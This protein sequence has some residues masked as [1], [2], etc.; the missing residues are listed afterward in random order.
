MKPFWQVAGP[1]ASA[2]WSV[3]ALLPAQRHSLG[4]RVG[5]RTYRATCALPHGIRTTSTTPCTITSQSNRSGTEQFFAQYCTNAVDH[6][7]PARVS[8]SSSSTGLQLPQRYHI[9]TSR[10]LMVC[11]CRPPIQLP[12]IGNALRRGRS[13]PRR[14]ELR[15]WASGRSNGIFYQPSILA[16]IG[17]AGRSGR[18]TA[19][20]RREANAPVR[21]RLR[22]RR[23]SPT[24]C[25]Q[26]GSIGVSHRRTRTLQR[27]DLGT[28]R[29]LTGMGLH[30]PGIRLRQVQLEEMDLLAYP[31]DH[32]AKVHLRM[33]RRMRQKHERL[34]VAWRQSPA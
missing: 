12:G 29:R 2:T 8:H 11:A 28:L 1:R 10:S 20:D 30:Q 16:L 4:R 3:R 27:A 15:V 6:T 34:T 19:S 7:R 17:L 21:A 5:Q 24:R 33:G 23:P 13:A 31:A 14:L 9:G 18:R 32:L 22:C 25:Y 26:T